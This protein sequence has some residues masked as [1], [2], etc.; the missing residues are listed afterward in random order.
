[1][2]NYLNN[3]EIIAKHNDGNHVNAEPPNGERPHDRNCD[4]CGEA[5]D[6]YSSIKNKLCNLCQEDKY[7]AEYQD[8]L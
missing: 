4:V 7:M 1:M 6:Y 8:G 2:D 3:K 5:Y